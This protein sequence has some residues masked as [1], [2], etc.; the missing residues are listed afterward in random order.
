MKVLTIEKEWVLTV[1]HD[2][3]RLRIS[4]GY[5]STR[6]VQCIM[7]RKSIKTIYMWGI[8][9]IFNVKKNKTYITLVTC[10]KLIKT[11]YTWAISQIFN[12]KKTYILLVTC[13]KLIKTIYTW[14]IS[15]MFKHIKQHKPSSNNI[16][17]VRVKGC[18]NRQWPST[19]PNIW[20]IRDV[21]VVERQQPTLFPT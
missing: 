4:A 19:I 21:L 10:R 2:N 11:I 17:N 15:H 18:I 7:C 5:I 9:Q 20:Q 14:T 1:R 3:I 6:L 8:S 13:R 12:K 16:S